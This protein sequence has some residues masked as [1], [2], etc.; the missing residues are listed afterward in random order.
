[1]K[2]SVVIPAYNAGRTLTGVIERIPADLFAKLDRI[3]IVNDGS[4]DD[5]AEQADS[6]A[7][8]H[9]VVRVIHLE[10]NRGYGGAMK[11]ALDAA[12]E[13]GIEAVACLHADGQYAPESLPELLEVRDRRNLDILQGS[14]LAQGTA[15]SGGM[16]LYKYVA[17]QALVLIENMVFDLGLTDY[18]SGYMIYGRRALKQIPYNRLSDGFEF[19]LEMIASARARGLAVGEWPIPTRYADERSYLNPVGY[20]IKVL[21]VLWGYRRGKYDGS[22]FT[23]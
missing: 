22:T 3:W 23:D 20:G 14:R 1:M 10:R 17:G 13:N 4:L 7:V 12:L 18:H 19:D 11:R 6:L 16:P 8:L 15:L 21:S 9:Q 5:T 2:I